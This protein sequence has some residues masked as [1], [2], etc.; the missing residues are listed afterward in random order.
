MISR[1]SHVAVGF[2][3]ASDAFRAVAV[4]GGRVVAAAEILAG[5]DSRSGGDG[6]P[7]PMPLS[8]FRRLRNSMQRQGIDAGARWIGLP[9]EPS[10]A[11]AVLDL[12][13]RASGAPIESLAAAELAR[14][15]DRRAMEAAVWEIPAGRRSGPGPVSYLAVGAATGGILEIVEAASRV[16]IELHAIDTPSTAIARVSGPGVRLA[17]ELGSASLRIHLCHSGTPVFSHVRHLQD[18]VLPTDRLIDEIDRCATYIAGRGTRADVEGIVLSGPGARDGV[19]VDRVRRE[20]DTAV[21][22][23]RGAGLAS[24]DAM[25][26]LHAD[27]AFAQAA[28]LALWGERAM[29]TRERAA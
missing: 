17:V 20:F 28:G 22:V 23:W 15:A 7:S 16:G 21:S 27:P 13:P 9:P 1:A 10:L 24:D 11:A 6:G 5:A 18:A 29:P 14:G 26:S 2:E 25:Q 19:L 12:P 4:R 3:P 8:M